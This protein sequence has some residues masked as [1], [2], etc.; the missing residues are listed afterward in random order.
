MSEE[1]IKKAVRES[2][3]HEVLRPLL[4]DVF[5]FVKKFLSAS[6]VQIWAITLWVAHTYVYE[7]GYLTPY[8]YVHSAEKRSGK[9]LLLEILSLLVRNPWLTGRVSTAVLG[10]K[11]SSESPTLLLDEADAAFGSGREYAEGVRGVLNLGFKQGG[12]TTVAERINGKWVPMDFNN[13]CPKAIALIGKL[14]GTLQDRSIDLTLKRKL[15]GEVVERFR[16]RKIKPEADSLK[17]RLHNWAQS[18]SLDSI[19]V[20]LPDELS[21]RAQDIWEILF[22]IAYEAR[23]EWPMRV[24]EASLHLSG[25]VNEDPS[26]KVGLLTDISFVFELAGEERISSAE[27]LKGLNDID[28]SSWAEMGKNGLTRDASISPE[29]ADCPDCGS[30]CRSSDQVRWAGKGPLPSY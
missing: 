26:L 7:K 29:T 3:S 6:H 25:D 12:K 17:D 11:I 16:E 9:T 14:P 22:Q 20:E 27:L 15:R 18:S 10:R 24:Y 1:L 30:K 2:M 13:F 21:D 28:D 8:L 5:S 4:E 19:D 23:G